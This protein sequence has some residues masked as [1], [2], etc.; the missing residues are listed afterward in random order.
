[1]AMMATRKHLTDDFF[2]QQS[3]N[4]ILMRRVIDQ[5]M[6]KKVQ[7]NPRLIFQAT[8]KI[9]AHYW[10]IFDGHKQSFIHGKR[11]YMKREVASLTKIM[12][13]YTVLELAK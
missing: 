2:L 4:S 7:A 12:T 5:E 8:P 10:A 9:S 13:A 3:K 11:E 1:M 6:K